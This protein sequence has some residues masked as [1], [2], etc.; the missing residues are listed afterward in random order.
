[1]RVC[2]ALCRNLYLPVYS[3]TP[4]RLL[5]RELRC[6]NCLIICM[7]RSLWHSSGGHEVCSPSKPRF[8]TET[9]RI[10][11]GRPRSETWTHLTNLLDC[12]AVMDT[13]LPMNRTATQIT[14]TRKI[15]TML[16]R[17]CS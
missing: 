8:R 12:C 6:S 9:G 14:N 1:P 11:R 16:V 17:S 4:H 2:N 13:L 10:L 3:H 7:V 15:D 5:L